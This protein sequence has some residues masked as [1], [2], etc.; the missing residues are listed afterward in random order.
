MAVDR[1]E[2][3]HI[4]RSRS[5]LG[6]AESSLQDG[7]IE[8]AGP[9]LW[10]SME[11]AVKAVAASRGLKLRSETNVW[12]YATAL[13]EIMGDESQFA[14]AFRY[15]YHVYVDSYGYGLALS[16]SPSLHEYIAAGVRELL[17][18]AASGSVR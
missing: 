6:D 14:L 1:P 13:A 10:R 15:A 3:E 18:L 8:A 16:D 2:E 12:N 7:Q 4:N 5:Y 11:E 9:S 17:D